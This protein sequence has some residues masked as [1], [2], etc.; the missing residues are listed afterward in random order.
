MPMRNCA[1]RSMALASKTSVRDT[2][3]RFESQADWAEWLATHCA[4]SS[5]FWLR[6]AKRGADQRSVSCR[7]ALEVALCY[8]WVDGQKKGE[9]EHHWLQRFTPR[10]AKSIWSKI[11]RGKALKLIQQGRIETAGLQEIERAK[12]DGRWE[13]RVRLVEHCHG[14]AGPAGGTRC[15]QTS[16]IILCDA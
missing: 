7:E 15:E 1:R 5:G 10:S 11:N 4:A 12:S 9:S 14:A 3:M 16:Q 2:P 8:G 13:A 6:L